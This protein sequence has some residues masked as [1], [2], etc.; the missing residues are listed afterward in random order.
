MKGIIYA[1]VEIS[2]DVSLQVADEVTITLPDGTQVS[3]DVGFE[4]GTT[5]YFD[6]EIEIEYEGENE[7]DE[8]YVQIAVEEYIENPDID[9]ASD[10]HFNDFVTVKYDINGEIGGVDIIEWS[11]EPTKE[12]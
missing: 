1:N 8:N 4:D 11:F 10:S 9:F 12:V 2:V 5:I 3:E 7:P 6:T